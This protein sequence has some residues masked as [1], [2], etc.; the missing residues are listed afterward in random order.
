MNDSIRTMNSAVKL[1]IKLL[2][3]SFLAV[4]L[5]ACSSNDSS[6]L[7]VEASDGVQE[8]QLEPPAM[9]LNR[10]VNAD[11]LLP[12]V[13]LN[14]ARLNMES[15][16]VGGGTVFQGTT[17]VI[18]GEDVALRV[19]WIEFFENRE[20]LLAVSETTYESISGNTNVILREDDYVFDDLAT[21]PRLDDDNDRVA[22][23]TEREEG[24]N[25]FSSTDPGQFRSNAF[26]NQIDPSR[27]PKI[28]GSYDTIYGE[29]QFRDRDGE[30]LYLNNRILGFDPE[31]PDTDGNTEFRWAG[32]HDGQYLYLYVFGEDAARRSTHG[33][34]LEPWQ[35][36][37][38]DI[39]WDGNRSR[40]STYDGVDDHHII[41]PLVKY[42]QNARNAS[43]LYSNPGTPQEQLIEGSPDPEGR[44]E[45]G[46]NSLDIP[47]V[48]GGLGFGGLDGVVFATCVCPE[49]D[50]YEI[51]LDLE[52]LQIP[53]DRSFGFEIQINNDV[54][55]NIRD[56]K[57]G[58]RAPDAGDELTNDITWE[59]PSSMGLLE[60]LP[61]E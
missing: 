55:G 51:R 29:A 31:R 56:S 10:A 13:T 19:D 3:S 40:G 24:S 21:Y 59:D 60:L 48:V 1:S 52:K 53:V 36:D 47:E 37:S 26:L 57:F 32:F 41:I 50:T 4:F 15:V 54:D 17:Q 7:S 5:S 38:I 58:W 12:D 33:D 11:L 46:F 35:D 27:A 20:L 25:P 44:A 8:W 43:N 18:E 61:V 6:S 34:S 28:D 14:G 49:T 2:V 30:L 23:L 16:N 22:N 9:L 45:T 42:G 39:F